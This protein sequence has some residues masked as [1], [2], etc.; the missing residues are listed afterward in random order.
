MSNFL[1]IRSLGAELFDA[2]GKTDGQTTDVTKLIV[3]FCSFAKSPNNVIEYGGLFY[4]LLQFKEFI[5][6]N[7]LLFNVFKRKKKNYKG[8][9]RIH[10]KFCSKFAIMP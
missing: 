5:F 2:S 3:V 9:R 7:Y 1:Q 10:S 4:Y 6:Q 8:R